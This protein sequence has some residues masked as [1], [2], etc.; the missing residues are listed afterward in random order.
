MKKDAE[1]ITIEE[2]M[3]Y[4]KRSKNHCRVLLRKHFNLRP[5]EKVKRVD[6]YEFLEKKN[7][8]VIDDFLQGD[9]WVLAR[10]NKL[11][12]L[13]NRLDD[14][15]FLAEKK[16]NILEVLIEFAKNKT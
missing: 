15:L 1:Y 16:N 6:F 3:K 12:K 14:L 4:F 10:R 7:N 5:Y 8:V 13:I 2:V 9:K 11:E